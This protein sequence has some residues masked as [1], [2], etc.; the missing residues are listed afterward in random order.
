MVAPGITAPVGSVTLPVTEVLC[1]NKPAPKDTRSKNNNSH[2]FIRDN[3]F[4]G[5]GSDGGGASK[6]TLVGGYSVVAK[7]FLSGI[8]ESERHVNL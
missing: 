3:P 1:A 2:L 7:A 5:S 6:S 4:I 8:Q